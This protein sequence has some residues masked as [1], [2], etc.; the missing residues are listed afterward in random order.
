MST[1][2]P[3]SLRPRQR[4]SAVERRQ[5]IMRAASELF[6]EHGYRGA[7]IDEIARRSGVSPPVVYDHF[8]SKVDLYGQL[9]EAHFADLRRIWAAHLGE[10]GMDSGRVADAV[11]AWFAYVEEHPFAGR[12]LFSETTGDPEADQ[13]RARIA[14]RSR[15]TVMAR[16]AAQLGT[17]QL[18][19]IDPVGQEMAWVVLRGV[20]QGL[21]VW[22]V[23]HP[24]VARKRV[25]TTAMNALWLGLERVSAGESWT[26][27]LD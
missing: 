5:M 9:L 21:A 19:G 10:D 3:D 13:I 6:A 7:S 11:T 18:A 20:L 14:E 17:G 12:A 16:F 1:E 8:A 26:G 4:L 25:V 27:S 24:Q 22:W 23:D 2:P 15:D